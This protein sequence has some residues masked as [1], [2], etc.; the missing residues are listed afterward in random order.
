MPP[1]PNL[2]EEPGLE[3]GCCKFESYRRYQTE[4]SMKP[5]GFKYK[6]PYREGVPKETIIDDG[7]Y[8]DFSP[9]QTYREVHEMGHNCYMEEIAD[10]WDFLDK[11]MNHVLKG[12][13]HLAQAM[14]LD[15]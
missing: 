6:Q 13:Y 7:F 10:R 5:R 12:E 2:A 4:E 1:Y 15:W 11:K 3:P 9:L 14:E 8:R